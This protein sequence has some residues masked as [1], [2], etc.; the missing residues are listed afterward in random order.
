MK[1]LATSPLAPRLRFGASLLFGPMRQNINDLCKTG[2]VPNPVQAPVSS[3]LPERPK[4]PNGQLSAALGLAQA[5]L[6]PRSLMS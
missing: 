1:C 2:L 3:I 6:P 5:V 4:P